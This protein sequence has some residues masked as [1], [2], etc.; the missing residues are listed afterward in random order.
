M[1]KPTYRETLQRSELNSAEAIEAV[2]L[3]GR[4]EDATPFTVLI[5]PRDAF[6]RVRTSDPET[7]FDSTH[8]YDKSPLLFEEVVA[9]DTAAGTHLPAE[10]CVRMRVEAEGDSII[11]QSKQYIRYQPREV[12]ACDFDV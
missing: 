5:D 12:A 7:L 11:R 6:S 2:L 3:S 8:H 4:N 10:A 1:G 9:G